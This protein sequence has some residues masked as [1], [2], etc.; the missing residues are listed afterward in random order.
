MHHFNFALIEI[1]VKKKKRL[2]KE[3]IDDKGRI[4]QTEGGNA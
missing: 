1:S 3:V 2:D 4:W